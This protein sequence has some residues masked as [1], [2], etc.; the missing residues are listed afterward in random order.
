MKM[1]FILKGFLAFSL[2]ASIYSCGGNKNNGAG[3]WTP[4]TP[5]VVSEKKQVLLEEYTGQLCNN[6]PNAAKELQKVSS[7][8]PKNAII[9][10]MHP[11]I[12]G[13]TKNLSNDF[14]DKVFRKFAESHGTLPGLIINRDKV[15]NDK[16]FNTDYASWATKIQEQINKQALYRISIEAKSNENSINVS[17]TAKSLS[18]SNKKDLKLNL[19][20]VEDIVDIQKLPNGK[21]DNAYHHH[22]VFRTSLTAMEGIDFN[23]ANTYSESYDIS[24]IDKSINLKNAKIIAFLSDASSN[25]VYEANISDI[26]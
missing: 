15:F 18:E 25:I 1:N 21:Y 22:N 8:Y 19:I 20:L 13:L 6:C 23:I 7:L 17:V 11:K 26:I 2:I 3:N 9:V 14:A 10:S 5:D 16:Y 12:Q 4:V 24:K